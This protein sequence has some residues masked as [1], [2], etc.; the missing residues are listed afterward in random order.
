MGAAQLADDE[1]VEAAATAS[2]GDG[3]NAMDETEAAPV[4]SEQ[5]RTR[6]VPSRSLGLPGH[7]EPVSVW[8]THV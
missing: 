8:F 2:A 4:A 5:A 7:D 1:E 6:C 3:G